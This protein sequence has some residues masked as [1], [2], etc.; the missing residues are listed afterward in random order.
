[1]VTLKFLKEWA[2]KEGVVGFSQMSKAELERLWEYSQ[3][4]EPR[5]YLSLQPLKRPVVDLLANRSMTWLRRLK[6]ILRK[7]S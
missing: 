4:E 6:N 7:R 1:M 3:P 2:R 5:K